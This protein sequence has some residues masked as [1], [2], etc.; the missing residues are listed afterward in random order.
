LCLGAVALIEKI[1]EKVEGDSKANEQKYYSYGPPVEN[2]DSMKIPALGSRTGY[3]SQPAEKPVF[4]RGRNRESSQQQNSESG[5]ESNP[6]QNLQPFG[7]VSAI[8]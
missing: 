2:P 8:L 7:I 5:N 1:N 4:P 3:G 6:H